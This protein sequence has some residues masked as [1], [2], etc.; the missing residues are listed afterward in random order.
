MTGRAGVAGAQRLSVQDFIDL[1]EEDGYRLELSRGRLVREPGPGPLHSQVTGRLFVTLWTFVER[2]GLGLV[3]VES[4]FTLANDEAIVRVS[5]VA[6]VSSERI[7]EEGVTHRFWELAP[8]LV[9]EVVSPSNRVS[10]MQ[11]KTM[12]YLRA[13]TRLLWIVDPSER[14]VTVYRSRSDIR[15]LEADDVL[16]GEDVLPGLR[17]PVAELFIV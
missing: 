5:D 14:T 4:A 15:I 16:A 13:G 3:F 6:F 2:K 10:E 11:Q 9:V 12:E 7:P 8:D 1:P 17:I